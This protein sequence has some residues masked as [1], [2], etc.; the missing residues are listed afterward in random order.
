MPGAVNREHA[1]RVYRQLGRIS[2]QANLVEP[3]DMMTSGRLNTLGDW[4]E[5]MP[6]ETRLAR[7]ILL[8]LQGAIGGHA[9]RCCTARRSLTRP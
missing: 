3:G 9:R 8:S 1:Y 6:E 7:P 2:A 4:L 5:N